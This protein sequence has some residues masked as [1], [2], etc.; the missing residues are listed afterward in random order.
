MTF[1][2][3]AP[4]EVDYFSSRR[5]FRWLNLSDL[6]RTI[7]TVQFIQSAAQHENRKKRIKKRIRLDQRNVTI[8]RMKK[9]IILQTVTPENFKSGPLMVP[10]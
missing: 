7:V 3:S 8:A 4:S 6:S 1:R 9:P 2:L 5:A 10:G